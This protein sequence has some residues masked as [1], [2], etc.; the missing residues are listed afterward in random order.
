MHLKLIQVLLVIPTVWFSFV[1]RMISVCFLQ[2]S[3]SLSV[4]MF[5]V[6]VFLGPCWKVISYV[7]VC[8]CP[9]GRKP[10]HI[11]LSTGSF[12]NKQSHVCKACFSCFSWVYNYL[13]S[14]LH[15]VTHDQ[16]WFQPRAAVQESGSLLERL[17]PEPCFTDSERDPSVFPVPMKGWEALVRSSLALVGDV[18]IAPELPFAQF[19]MLFLLSWG[20]SLAPCN[21]FPWEGTAT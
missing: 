4:S 7:N 3:N 11:S 9:V 5:V 6:S 2:S 18:L 8:F 17:G 10:T 14:L 21:Q 12:W 15:F 13:N 19:L 20:F 16:Q 1:G